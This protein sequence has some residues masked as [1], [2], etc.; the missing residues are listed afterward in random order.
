MFTAHY[1]PVSYA[2]QSSVSYPVDKA[3]E[4]EEATDDVINLQ[5]EESTVSARKRRI[6]SGDSAFDKFGD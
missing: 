3:N 6:E 5:E 2:R 1:K 4:D